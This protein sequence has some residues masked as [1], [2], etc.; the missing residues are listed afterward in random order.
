MHGEEVG[1]NP[2]I[3]DDLFKE[4]S[5]LD[6]AYRVQSAVLV[7]RHIVSV[8]APLAFLEKS[9]LPPRPQAPLLGRRGSDRWSRPLRNRRH[10]PRKP[11][12]F[13]RRISYSV[14]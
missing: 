3:V 10:V 12:Y 4:L 9:S 2:L 6:V 14:S 8:R 1:P 7:K 13:V 5:G 11:P